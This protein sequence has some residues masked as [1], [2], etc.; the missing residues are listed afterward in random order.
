MSTTN[1]KQVLANTKLPTSKEETYRYFNIE[2]IYREEVKHLETTD[3][4][5]RLI[6]N[7]VPKREKGKHPATRSFQ[8]IRIEINN[9]LEEIKSGLQQ[10][11]N[12]LASSGR[13]VVISFHS[14]EDRIVKRFIRNET[15][16][17]VNPGRLPIKE[18]DIERG[19][20]NKIGKAIKAG[21]I[22]L[23]NNPRARSAV[24]RVAERV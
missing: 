8:A 18:I 11:I 23:K 21:K 9:E 3:E 6:E 20:L 1:L 15:G 14:L 17:K 5:A 2:K 13:L 4:L 24:M 22:E 10:A 7:V 19:I 16:R 12:I